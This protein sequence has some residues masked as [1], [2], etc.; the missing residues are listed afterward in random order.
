[1]KKVTISLESAARKLPFRTRKLLN[2]H[3]CITLYG[4]ARTSR[5]APRGSWSGRARPGGCA[6]TRSRPPPSSSS[7]PAIAQRFPRV[8][9]RRVV[10]PLGL[11]GQAVQGGPGVAL[12]YRQGRQAGGMARRMSPKPATPACPACPACPLRWSADRQFVRRLPDS[13]PPSLTATTPYTSKPQLLSMPE[14]D[15]FRRSLEPS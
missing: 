6:A 12:P 4:T 14:R 8:A 11:L 1:M 9:S 3:K 5:R 2:H 15:E 13:M 10:Q 7:W